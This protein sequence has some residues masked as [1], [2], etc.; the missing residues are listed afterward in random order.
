M[1]YQRPM[2]YNSCGVRYYKFD[3]YQWLII[4]STLQGNVCCLTYATSHKL[5]P[6]HG[7]IVQSSHMIGESK[8]WNF[9]SNFAYN[10][11]QLTVRGYII[12]KEPSKA[13]F[14]IYTIV[15]WY[16]SHICRL[17]VPYDYALWCSPKVRGKNSHVMGIML[18]RMYNHSPATS[19]SAFVREDYI[20]KRANI[21]FHNLEMKLQNFHLYLKGHSLSCEVG[22]REGDRQRLGLLL[23]NCE[24]QLLHRHLQ[25]VTLGL[26]HHWDNCTLRK[27]KRSIQLLSDLK[28][29]FEFWRGRL[30]A[31]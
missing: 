22:Q 12:V 3:M 11:L 30:G 7:I 18:D 23:P 8:S 31:V 17:L 26:R 19:Y 29:C 25:Q 15:L 5:E 9:S 21:Q 24:L 28:L 13:I 6:G 14:L 10:V 27:F 2:P 20:Q 16:I 1:R 4:R